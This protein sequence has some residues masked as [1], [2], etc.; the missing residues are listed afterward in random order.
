MVLRAVIAALALVALSPLAVVASEPT[1]AAQTPTTVTDITGREVTVNVPV[2]RVL[3]GEGRQLY[4]LASLEPQ[5]PLARVVAWRNDLIEADPATYD[6]YLQAF[7]GLAKLPA[8][9]GQEN[10]LID[11][12]ST[13]VQKPDVVLLNLEAMRA[14]EDAEYIQKLAELKIPVLYIDFRHYP[15]KNT[16]P[17]IRLLG[18]ILGR[19]ARA[20]EIIAFRHEAMARVT[21]VIGRAKPNRPKVFIE[22]IGGY[23]DDCCLSFGAENFG[24]YVELAGGHNLGSDFL[25]STF[26]QLN[27]EQVVA[28]NPEHVVVTSANWQ[29]YV[30]GGHWIPL[31]PGADPQEMRKK[32][33]W[34]TTRDAYTGIAAQRTRSFHG[35][36][37]QFYNSPYEF[38]AVQ[39]LAKWFHPDLFADLDPDATFAEYHRR[40]LPIPYRPGYAISLAGAD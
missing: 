35:I 5:D 14:N 22:R 31:G 32:L 25:P 37:H 20:E 13:I 36:W 17:T 10:G 18:K 30:P 33:D 28:S 3:L 21:D 34:F 38:F 4:L 40:F 24:K 12:E 39:Q 27:P 15:L 1:A 19:E 7:P 23:A 26:G 11:I 2:K 9:P 29:A 6:Q 8:F 16:E